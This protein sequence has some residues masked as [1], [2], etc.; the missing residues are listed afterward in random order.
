[1]GSEVCEERD[2]NN[3][4]S[5]RYYREGFT[6]NSLQATSN[7]F[8]TR[9]HL[10][11]IREVTNSSG[12][13]Q[14][15]YDYDPYGRRTKVGEGVDADVG[16]TGHYYHQP[17]AL[18]LALYRAYDAN[19]GRWISRDPAEN[20]ES[21]QEGPNLYSYVANNPVKWI[22][23]L[24]LSLSDWFGFPSRIEHDNRDILND[25]PKNR[26]NGGNAG[27]GCDGKTWA[28]DPDWYAAT[29]GGSGGSIFRSDEG[30][31]CVYDKDGNLLPDKGTFNYTASPRTLGHVWKDVLPH[32]WYGGGYTPNQTT[33]Y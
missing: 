22:D 4:V 18:N 6:V 1:V 25:C 27:E 19:L 24:G 11:S 26:P 20:A 29:K 23:P 12:T 14:A 30:D 21:L 3:G 28:K 15:R 9:D 5:K 7:Y 17:S 31:E 13:V 10:G 16:F 33:S 8:F 32:F 2:A